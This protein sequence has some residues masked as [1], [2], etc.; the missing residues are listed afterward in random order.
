MKLICW[1]QILWF[2]LTMISDDQTLLSRLSLFPAISHGETQWHHRHVRKKNCCHVSS[3]TALF[4]A[5]FFASQT[6]IFLVPVVIS[7]CR[8]VAVVWRRRSD[9]WQRHAA[10]TH[11]QFP[12]A[13]G[14]ELPTGGLHSTTGWTKS[15]AFN[16]HWPDAYNIRRQWL[17]TTMHTLMITVSTEI[18]FVT[19]VTWSC[20]P[21]CVGLLQ[22]PLAGGCF[23]S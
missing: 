2:S 9:R 23:R 18:I 13:R 14:P 15:R 12:N 4:P 17:G 19:A 11:Q 10:T 7:Q 3:M 5:T 20:V 16:A 6:F 1:F 22:Q 21:Q 8:G